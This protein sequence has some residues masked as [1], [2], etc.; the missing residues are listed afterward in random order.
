M[1]SLLGLTCRSCSVATSA[2]ENLC[3]YPLA[4]ML[5]SDLISSRLVGAGK[6]SKQSCLK[7]P[8]LHHN[9][10]VNTLQNV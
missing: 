4:F 5:L 2:C 10:Y 8:G 9:T 6:K 3:L 7:E 1:K